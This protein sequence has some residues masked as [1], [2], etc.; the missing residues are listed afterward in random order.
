MTIDAAH[1]LV[2]IYG[3]SE[4]CEAD[5]KEEIARTA[6]GRK[7]FGWLEKIGKLTLVGDGILVI[8]GM[9]DETVE[10]YGKLTY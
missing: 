7:N 6:D 10:S 2:I 5:I 3:V 4:S 9:S 1:N 8:S